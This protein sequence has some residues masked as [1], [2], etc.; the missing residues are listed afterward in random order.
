MTQSKNARIEGVALSTRVWLLMAEAGGWWSAMEV[1]DFLKGEASINKVTWT[2]LAMLDR[3]EVKRMDGI[4]PNYAVLP[5][6]VVPRGVTCERLMS[7]MG[8]RA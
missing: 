7:A 4:H 5:A 8:A 3:G 1:R 2:L 6:C